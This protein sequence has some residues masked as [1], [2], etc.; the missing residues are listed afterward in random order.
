MARCFLL[1]LFMA[2]SA[3]AQLISIGIK[4]G[5]PANDEFQTSFDYRNETKRYV[6]GPMLQV[7]LPLRFAVEV[8][9]L[10]KRIGYSTRTTDILGSLFNASVRANSWEV[11]FILKY[12]LTGGLIR[13]YVGAG[14]SIQGITNVTGAV[15][16]FSKAV[17]N[18]EA[19]LINNPAHGVVLEGGLQV[20][21][22]FL[23]IEPE[24]RYT[25]WKDPA[26]SI[27][28]SRGAFLESDQ[29][30]YEFLVGIRF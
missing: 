25:R 24:F 3:P 6:I 14:Y 17:F 26:F 23:K 18:P 12:H 9:G 21:A 11:P 30:Q 20:R 10:Y 4:G 16:A 8:D 2:G 19:N 22:L 5:V 13:P 29:N 7:N 1:L 27:N 15:S 28:G